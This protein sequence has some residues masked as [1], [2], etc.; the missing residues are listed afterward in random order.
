MR[1]SDY[2]TLTSSSRSFKHWQFRLQNLDDISSRSLQ[3]ASFSGLHPSKA[4]RSLSDLHAYKL[5][6]S[7]K[8]ERTREKSRNTFIFERYRDTFTPVDCGRATNQ[9]HRP[10]VKRE[11]IQV[12]KCIR[13]IDKT[14][15]DLYLIHQGNEF[16][17]PSEKCDGEGLGLE[18]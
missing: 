3:R 5:V 11:K 18:T 16:R 4:E 17:N 15:Q 2:S 6:Y 7:T 13:L 1:F 12:P 8:F 10:K 14:R 9:V